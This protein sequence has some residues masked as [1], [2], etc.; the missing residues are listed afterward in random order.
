LNIKGHNDWNQKA[1]DAIRVNMK[2]QH[3]QMKEQ[4]QERHKDI[5]NHVGG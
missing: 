5:A 4:L 3:M 2:D 1:L